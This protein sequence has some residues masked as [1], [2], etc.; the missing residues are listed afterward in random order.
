MDCRFIIY[1][2]IVRVNKQYGNL[3][4]PIG[5]IINELVYQGEEVINHI[6]RFDGFI[7]HP[8]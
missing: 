3:H 4:I 2:N 7:V 8:S 5:G 1:T 6:N